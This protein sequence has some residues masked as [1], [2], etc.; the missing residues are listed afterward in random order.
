MDDGGQRVMS[1]GHGKW[2]SNGIKSIYSLIYQ[3]YF[4]LYGLY[5]RRIN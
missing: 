2:N 5:K 4:V 1:A 3:I